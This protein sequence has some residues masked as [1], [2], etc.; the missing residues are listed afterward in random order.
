MRVASRLSL[1]RCCRVDDTGH[2]AVCHRSRGQGVK[3]PGS[4]GDNR[5]VPL[6]GLDHLTGG[7]TGD[8]VARQCLLIE[9][10]I[11]RRLRLPQ[12]LAR[13]RQQLLRPRPRDSVDLRESVFARP[14]GCVLPAT[15]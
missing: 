2:L 10:V 14:G 8:A 3:T 11:R 6:T 13:L 1:A 5:R 9:T 7:A 12:S 15:A 4:E